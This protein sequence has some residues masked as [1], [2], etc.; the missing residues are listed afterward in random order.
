MIYF[1]LI[2]STCYQESTK[3]GFIFFGQF[4]KYILNL[5]LQ[6]SRYLGTEMTQSNKLEA[7]NER[8]ASLGV[9]MTQIRQQNINL[10]NVLA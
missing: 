3:I 5:Q 1:I 9:E 6:H 8:F 7:L 4:Y 2:Q 10:K